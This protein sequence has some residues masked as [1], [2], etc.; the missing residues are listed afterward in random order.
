MRCTHI[1]PFSDKSDAFLFIDDDFEFNAKNL[2]NYVRNFERSKRRQLLSGP[3]M[4]WRRVIRPF[5]N[6]E[7]NKW[8]ITSQEVPWAR[9]PPY[10]WGVATII[11]AEVLTELV[12]AEAYTRFLWVDDAFLGFVVA[13]LPLRNFQDMKGFYLESVNNNKALVSHIPFQ[14][15]LRWALDNANQL[16]NNLNL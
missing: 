16:F 1:C 9:L 5:K 15:S 2:L 3:L 14:F 4:Y 12:V 6:A 8:A 13:K 11:G 10:V 7:R